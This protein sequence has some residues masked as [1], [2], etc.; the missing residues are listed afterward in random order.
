[1]DIDSYDSPVAERLLR[2]AQ[3][4]YSD[5]GRTKRVLI[6]EAVAAAAFLIAA[7]LLANLA[8]WNRSLSVGA[9]AATA[10]LYLVASQVKFPVGSGWTVPT[11][12][13]FVPMLF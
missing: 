7:G 12:L 2:A 8:T 4:R 11:Q 10:V 6:T 9:L 1:M 3:E 5:P 13:A